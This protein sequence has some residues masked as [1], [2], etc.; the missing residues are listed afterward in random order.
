RDGL[1][2]A[3]RDALLH[4]GGRVPIGVAGLVGVDD[5]C[6]GGDEGHR[7]AR[8]GADAGRARA[9]AHAQ[10]RAGARA[11]GIGRATHRR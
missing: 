1:R 3:D 9:Q 4:L 8:Q 10:E 7:V 2:R 11:H 5:A 6:A